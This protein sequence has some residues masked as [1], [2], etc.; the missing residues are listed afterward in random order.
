MYFNVYTN[1]FNT[2]EVYGRRKKLTKLVPTKTPTR[3]KVYN[4][5]I[6]TIVIVVK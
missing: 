5:T 6:T 1:T 3:F 4:V 2:K